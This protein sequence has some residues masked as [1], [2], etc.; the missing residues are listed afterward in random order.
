MFLFVVLSYP[1][2]APNEVAE[3][4]GVGTSVGIGAAVI[5]FTLIVLGLIYLR[6]YVLSVVGF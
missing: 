5:I 4:Q 2:V 6:L 1:L 3:A